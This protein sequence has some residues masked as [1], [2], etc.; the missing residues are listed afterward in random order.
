MLVLRFQ[1]RPLQPRGGAVPNPSRQSLERQRSATQDRGRT[2]SEQVADAIRRH[3]AGDREAMAD[4]ARIVSPWLHALARG[5]GLSAHST[6]DVVQ[7]T[8]LAVLRGVNSIRSPEAGLAWL[9]V[10]ARREA[11]RV[12]QADRAVD[13]VADVG[14][15]TADPHDRGP[16][17]IAIDRM[18]QKLLWRHVAELPPRAQLILHEIAQTGRPDYAAFSRRT[19]MPIGSIGP[20][21]GRSLLRIRRLLEA[22]QDWTAF[23]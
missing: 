15:D 6:E 10:T 22:D 2:M 18:R 23:A 13:V 19:G 7:A 14:G 4:L 20:T 5:F 1:H 3:R 17:A 21:R 9:A 16:E 12:A 8:L 11:I